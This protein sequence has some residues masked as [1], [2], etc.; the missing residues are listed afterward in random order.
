[1]PIIWILLAAIPAGLTY[2]DIPN[3]QRASL[4]VPMLVIIIAYGCFEIWKSLG[5]TNLRIV[6]FSLSTMYLTLNIISFI[7][8]YFQHLKTNEPWYRSASEADLLFTLNKL[9]PK[10]KQIR[11][12]SSGNNT[13]IHFLFYNRIDPIEYQKMGSPQGHEGFE[14]GKFR[15]TGNPCPINGADIEY[16]TYEPDILY[17]NEFSCKIPKNA[18]VIDTIYNPDGT[19]V[20][21]LIKTLPAVKTQP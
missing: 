3:I 15:Y 11:M 9:A 4:M 6:I 21:K 7:H 2:E 12:T 20:F 17:V 16:A 8:I 10:Y 13:F 18:E 19:G 5:K 14:F 1:L